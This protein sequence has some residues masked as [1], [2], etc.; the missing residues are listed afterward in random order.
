MFDLF[1]WAIIFIAGFYVL[2]K[3]S[4]YFVN[5]AE[6]V[7]IHFGIPAFIV[8][9]TYSPEADKQRYAKT[10]E[11]E[12]LCW[13]AESDEVAQNICDY[14]KGKGMCFQDDNAVAG[15]WVFLY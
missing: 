10:Q 5:S 4:G 13:Q 12:W 6:K 8:G 15:N 2:I 11:S 7:G 14:F 1:L 9:V 3:S